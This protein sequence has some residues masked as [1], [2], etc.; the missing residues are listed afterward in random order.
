MSYQ[1]FKDNNF[2]YS[3]VK[4]KG[5]GHEFTQETQQV[6]KELILE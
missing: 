6:M 4:E 1:Y 3:F 2:N 5:K